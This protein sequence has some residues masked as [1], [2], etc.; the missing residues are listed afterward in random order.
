MITARILQ[1]DSLS[2]GSYYFS[3]IAYIHLQIMI[4]RNA[5]TGPIPKNT[6]LYPTR[7]KLD[8]R[9]LYIDTLAVRVAVALPPSVSSN[10]W[11]MNPPSPSSTVLVPLGPCE[12]TITLASAVPNLLFSSSLPQPQALPQNHPESE[13]ANR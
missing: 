7:L 8:A 6:H 12:T 1:K 13:S 3:I 5:I 9:P 4:L 10:P 11:V 2:R